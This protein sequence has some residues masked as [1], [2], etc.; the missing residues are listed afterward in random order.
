M[1]SG[2]VQA[3]FLGLPMLLSMNSIQAKKPNILFIIADDLRPQLNCYGESQMITP[4]IDRLAQMGVRFNRA[5]C[6]VPASGASRASLLSGIRPNE[7]RF[8]NAASYLQKD[9]PDAL[10]MPQ[11]FKGNNYRTISIGKVFH[12]TDDHQN[13]WDYQVGFDH[14]DYQDSISVLAAEQIKKTKNKD[15]LLVGPVSEK[16][17]VSDSAYCDGKNALFAARLIKEAA[18]NEKPFFMSIGFVRPHLPFIAPEKYWNMYQRDKLKLA[19]NP[20]AP[21]NCPKQALGNF[22]E[23][24]RMYLNIPK[25]GT[26]SDSLSLSLIHGYYASCSYMDAQ[27]GIVLDTLESTGQMEN[28]IIIF[29]GDHG[30]LLGEHG[31]WC[32]HAN[33]H[34]AL[35]APMIIAAPGVRGNKS[36]DAIVE[37]VD[38]FPTL[39][40]LTGVNKPQQLQ[41]VDLKPVL[42]NSHTNVKKEAYSRYIGGETVITK[43]FMYTEW[44]EPKTENTIARMLY[45]FT[46]DKAENFNIAENEQYKNVTHKL[47]RK[48]IE[49]KRKNKSFSESNNISIPETK[50]AD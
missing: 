28:T 38:I 46:S 37:F 29:I 4:N 11:V 2:K 40:E 48:L 9:A 21:Q 15:P 5:Y 3:A 7:T 35:N 8:A 42:K 16:P 36:T 13:A 17:D 31:L 6:Q 23:L 43:R 1:K 45:D 30:W 27:L 49:N 34:L 50:A 24:R 25:T 26:L 33:F 44:F 12:H 19:D 32:K 39:C 47:H 10:S 14:F 18:G 22:A 20:F 41:G